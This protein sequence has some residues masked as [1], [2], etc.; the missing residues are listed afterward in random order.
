MEILVGGGRG[1]GLAVLLLLLALMGGVEAFA[2]HGAGGFNGRGGAG[3]RRYRDLAAGRM[4]SVRSSFGAPR[5]GLATVSDYLL[6]NSLPCSHPSA[7]LRFSCQALIT[8]SLPSNLFCFGRELFVDSWGYISRV[9]CPDHLD[10]GSVDDVRCLDF[11]YLH[12]AR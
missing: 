3:E 6:Q 12:E 4:Q 1:G 5:R 10:T 11:H 9:L 7:E 2:R 8:N